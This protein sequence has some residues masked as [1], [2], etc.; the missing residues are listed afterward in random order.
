MPGN[1]KY[2]ISYLSSVVKQDIPALS[3]EW[4]WRIKKT[5]E[6]KLFYNPEIFGKPLRG[7]LKNFRSLRVGDYRVIYLIEKKTV[8]VVVIEHRSV[9]YKHILKR[10]S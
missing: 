4:S 6:D 3:E 10:I 9:V 8:L 2:E 5:I 1:K 7:S